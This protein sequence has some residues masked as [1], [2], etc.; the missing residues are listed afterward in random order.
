[1]KQLVFVIFLALVIVNPL[2]AFEKPWEKGAEKKPAKEMPEQKNTSDQGPDLTAISLDKALLIGKKNA[3]HKV[4]V[5][6]DPDCP[7]CGKLHEE[8]KKVISERKD[9][10]FFIKLYPLVAFHKEAY[11]KSKSIVCNNSLKLL[12][13]NFNKKSIPKIDCE[14]REIDDNMELARELGIKVVPTMIF[15]NGNRVSGSRKSEAVI[16]L[17]EEN[18]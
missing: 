4:I 2:G 14:T 8:L 1:M 16:K 7:Y 13:D 10:A 6:T 17:V 18:K 5:F 15:A 12:E 11:W 9:I 3:E